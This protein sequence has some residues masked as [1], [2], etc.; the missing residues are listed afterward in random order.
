MSDE[1]LIGS[2]SFIKE[3]TVST[4]SIITNAINQVKSGIKKAIINA[5]NAIA[6]TKAKAKIAYENNCCFKDGF[7]DVA[8]NNA[9]KTDPIPIPAPVSS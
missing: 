6:S 5:N 9:A 4:N 8:F 3:L 2:S 1:S 7:L